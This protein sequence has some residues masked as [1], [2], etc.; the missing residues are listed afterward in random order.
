MPKYAALALLITMSSALVTACSSGGDDNPPPATGGTGGG[1]G[2][3]GGGGGGDGG[4]GTPTEGVVTPSNQAP[5]SSGES[6]TIIVINPPTN[7]TTPP[8]AEVTPPAQNP[9]PPAQSPQPGGQTWRE[10]KTI[11]QTPGQYVRLEVQSDDAGNALAVWRT[12]NA[13]QDLYFTRYDAATQ[14]WSAPALL[15]NL[16]GMVWTFDLEMAP[17][18]QAIVT[19]LHEETA[20]NVWVRRFNDGSWGAPEL[21]AEGA[22]GRP[23]AAIA[24]NGDAYV[25]FDRY[26]SANNT[27][28]F[29]GRA[30]L[31]GAAFG[32]EETVTDG[33]SRFFVTDLAI[34]GNQRIALFVYDDTPLGQL[35]QN[36]HLFATRFN[37]DS[38]SPLARFDDEGEQVYAGRVVM[39]DTGAARGYWITHAGIQHRFAPTGGEFGARETLPFPATGYYM[40]GAMNVAG[41]ALAVWS[42]NDVMQA[43][44]AT[45]GGSFGTPVTIFS[46]DG[47]I[48]SVF[49]PSLAPSGAGAALWMNGDWSDDEVDWQTYDL[50]GSVLH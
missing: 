47:Y 8:P 30:S 32:P 16:G 5:S 2:A 41:D 44:R 40:T 19:W 36:A 31:A 23:A 37:G 33:R 49:A 46:R 39:N 50:W 6:T 43:A 18:G 28:T 17:D 22:Y 29:Y 25:M 13:T 3:G 34:S 24:G 14:A 11:A 48:G 45:P 20:R 42:G 26:N 12:D 4:T 27:S 1:G 38:W 7:P 15:E 9:P 35:G 10:A 21:V